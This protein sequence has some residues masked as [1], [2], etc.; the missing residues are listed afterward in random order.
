MNN[1]KNAIKKLSV[2][3]KLRVI[4]WKNIARTELFTAEEVKVLEDM[5]E[6]I[7]EAVNHQ[8]RHLSDEGKSKLV[9]LEKV[10]WNSPI[11]KQPNVN[12]QEVKEDMLFWHFAYGF[13]FNEYASYQ[14][15]NK[16]Y[17]ER[18][19]F[20]SDRDSACLCYDLNDLEAR[21]I[22]ADKTK[23]YNNFK[24]YYGR[25]AIT[26]F[27]HSDYEKF[28]SFI[29]RHERFVKKDALESCGRSVEMIDLARISMS[30]EELFAMLISQGK[31]IIE[32][33]VVQSESLRMFNS[34]SV[35]TVRCITFHTKNGVIAPFFFMKTG[36]AGSFVDNG[37][38]GGLLVA[39]DN[40]TGCLGSSTDEY[41]NRFDSHP[42][43]GVSFRG[44]QLPE[45]KQMVNMCCEM[46]SKLPEVKVIGWDMAHTNHG[47][48]CIEGN[49]M[50]EA[51]GPQSTS[52]RGIR[53]EV[54]K[55]K[56]TL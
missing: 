33:L 42:D 35:N 39:I 16:D 15:I 41:G 49:S 36:R 12:V 52:L 4:K 54:E 1:L 53:S 13:T 47:W 2:V 46:A 32:E 44:F 56:L 24:S 25:D 29:K 19:S 38:A 7:S 43:S 6:R 5:P 11:S 37:S 23:T 22:L 26:V 55:L 9:E 14:F 40:T 8:L 3:K 34:S 18:R 30:P 50:T 31:L 10:F 51:I 20:L 17:E 21:M 48:V 27:K 45:W 28:L